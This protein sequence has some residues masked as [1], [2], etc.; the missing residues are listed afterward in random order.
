MIFEG[1]DQ[2]CIKY[3]SKDKLLIQFVIDV[4]NADSL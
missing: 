1:Q 2:T 3:V 4:G